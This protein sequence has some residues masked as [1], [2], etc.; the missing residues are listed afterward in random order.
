MTILWINPEHV[1]GQT[2]PSYQRIAKAYIEQIRT[3]TLTHHNQ[4]PPQR[5]LADRLS[6]TV[7]TVSRAYKQLEDQGYVYGHVGRG[8]FVRQQQPDSGFQIQQHIAENRSDLSLGIAPLT[9]QHFLLSQTLKQMSQQPKF[10]AS[11]MGYYSEQGMPHQREII[12][13]WLKQFNLMTSAEQLLL[14]NG[15]QHG[16]N[17]VIASICKPGDTV[18]CEQLS[19][20]GFIASA[21]QHR[22]QLLGVQLDEKGII[23]D[24]FEALC[25]KYQPRAIYLNPTLHNPTTN[26]TPAERRQQIVDIANKYNIWIIEDDVQGLLQQPRPPALY[27]YAPERV[28]YIGSFS[29]LLAGGLRSGWIISPQSTLPLLARSLR[30]NCWLTPPITHEIACRWLQ[31]GSANQLINLQ[32][33]TLAQ[34]HKMAANIL[35]SFN[36][37]THPQSYHIWLPLPPIWQAQELHNALA[38]EHIDITP[39]A[40]FAVGNA[41]IPQAVRISI[42]HIKEGNQLIQALQK[43]AELLNSIPPE[44]EDW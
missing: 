21:R 4:L 26:T 40:S 42:S 28:F 37:I 2:G 12:A 7:G 1:N 36:P 38:Q 10:L 30:A 14:T 43:I 25:Q 16:V 34:R 35:S 29:K 44:P 31:D 41:P 22:L 18:L 8:T 5:Q 13:S 9:E 24:H 3:C 17:I 19:Y 20:P 11:L 15:G 39:S 33:S 27:N 23:P 6:V 32:L